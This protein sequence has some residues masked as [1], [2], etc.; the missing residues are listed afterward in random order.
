MHTA[1]ALANALVTARGC[2]PWPGGQPLRYYRES[3]PRNRRKPHQ[4]RALHPRRPRCFASS[5]RFAP[6]SRMPLPEGSLPACAVDDVAASATPIRSMTDRPSLAPSSCTRRPPGSPCGSLS[7]QAVRLGRR[8]AYHVPSLLRC[9]EGRASPPVVRQ[10]R[11][12]SSEPP[13]LTTYLLVQAYPGAT[14]RR[15]R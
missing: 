1:Q 2:P 9:G 6:S 11:R 13:N 15:T 7:Q 12:G 5:S 3:Q 14:P 10:L 4:Q 8:R